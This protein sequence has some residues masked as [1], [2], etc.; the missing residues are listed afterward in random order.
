M[1]VF[2]ISDFVTESPTSMC[3]RHEILKL[4]T[5]LSVLELGQ[6]KPVSQVA[7]PFKDI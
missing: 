6:A 2:T 3:H 7:T 1:F 4:Q 5:Y